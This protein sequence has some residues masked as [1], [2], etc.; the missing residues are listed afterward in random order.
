MKKWQQARGRRRP[1]GIGKEEGYERVDVRAMG[2]RERGV[3]WMAGAHEGEI[4]GS[5]NS[6]AT[7]GTSHHSIK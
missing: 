6:S 7:V 2:G 3:G 5:Q 1:D 4:S